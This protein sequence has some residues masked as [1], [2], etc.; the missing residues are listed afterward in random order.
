MLRN[1]GNVRD[2]HGGHVRSERPR[3]RGP[4]GS[5]Q[6][7]RQGA[8]G[9]FTGTAGQGPIGLAGIIV[10]A[11]QHQETHHYP[12][13][14]RPA[15]TPGPAARDG[16]SNAGGDAPPASPSRRPVVHDAP[17]RSGPPWLS[18]PRIRSLGG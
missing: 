11:D 1:H 13:P 16:P 9:N 17:A 6:V 2:R 15:P 14:A 18:G 8:P 5:H 7:V 10:V 4:E 3:H 12:D